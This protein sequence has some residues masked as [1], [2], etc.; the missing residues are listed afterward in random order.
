MMTLN[1]VS[2]QTPKPTN[3]STACS[4]QERLDETLDGRER[5]GGLA[6]GKDDEILVL[7]VVVELQLV[8]LLVFVVLVGLS[9]AFAP[10]PG[11][12][13]GQASSSSSARLFRGEFLFVG[14]EGLGRHETN[15]C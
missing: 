14:R 7:I 9:V 10:R 5:A 1:S 4:C 12:T 11:E 8:F 3:D 6:R 2:T 15:R 13:L